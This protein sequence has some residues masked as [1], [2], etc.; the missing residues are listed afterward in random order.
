MPEMAPFRTGPANQEMT[1]AQPNIIGIQNWI[2]VNEYLT[3]RVWLNLQSPNDHSA[4]QTFQR[5][6]PMVVIA[7]F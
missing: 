5:L 3:I 7:L 1:L 4:I 6:L 2:K